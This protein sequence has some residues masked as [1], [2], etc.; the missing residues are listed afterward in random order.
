M[1]HVQMAEICAICAQALRILSE[2]THL[3][4]CSSES[5][6]QGV[7]VE[8]TSAF[9]RVR[10]CAVVLHLQACRVLT[11]VARHGCAASKGWDLSQY[12]S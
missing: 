12:S 7:R 2:Q 10:H 4:E 9:Q 5:V 6:T 1:D 11:I 3:L 8:V